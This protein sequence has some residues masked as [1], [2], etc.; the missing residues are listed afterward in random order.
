[1]M[2]Q[3]IVESNWGESQLSKN[4]NNFFGMKGSFDGQSVDMPTKEC[5]TSGSYYTID[6]K[7]KKYPNIADSINDNAALLKN[8]PSHDANYYSGSWK[9]NTDTYSDA[10]MALSLKY[11]T[12]TAYGDKLIDIIE[13][14]NLDKLDTKDSSMDIDKRIQKSLDKQLTAKA[15]ANDTTSVIETHSNTLKNIAK[16]NLT[17]PKETKTKNDKAHTWILSDLNAVWLL[18]GW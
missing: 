11:A 15:E 6:A 1:M 14:Y 18:R 2:A 5:T 8:G 9:K 7:F 13:T 4:A 16:Y 17:V 3:A 12:D 10:A